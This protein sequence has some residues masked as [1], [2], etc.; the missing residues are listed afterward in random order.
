LRAAF[1]S[2][3]PGSL[4]EANWKDIAGV[5]GPFTRR[6]L[7]LD[8]L[9]DFL[10]EFREVA[11]K[12]SFE[13]GMEKT[14]ALVVGVQEHQS[15]T[16]PDRVRHSRH[17][18][19]RFASLLRSKDC[20]GLLDEHVTTLLDEKATRGA[21]L[22]ALRKLTR[23]RPRDRVII[24]FA[25]Y[26]AVDK[27][28]RVYLVTSDSNPKYL[29]STAIPLDEL[30]AAVGKLR[31]RQVTIYLDTAFH[32]RREQRALTNAAVP[33]VRA[34]KDLASGGNV[35][36]VTACGPGEGAMEIPANK[37]G[38]FT[39]YLVRG[40]EGAADADR[41]GSIT[42]RELFTHLKESVSIEASLEA[43]TQEPRWYGA[44]PDDER[45]EGLGK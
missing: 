24:Y 21:V 41:D 18:A 25:G 38:I 32:A 31:A 45:V 10:T 7:E 4:G 23:S 28:G 6:K 12:D 33:P 13:A 1:S 15:P 39:Y 27:S 30:A 29:D 36:L 19:E 40:L 44:E 8:F 17:D 35:A 43:F 37:H 5:V 11:E 22:G 26:G 42:A 20:G 14:L 2:T 3:V 16:I 9:E 34:F